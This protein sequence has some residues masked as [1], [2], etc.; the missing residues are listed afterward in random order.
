MGF[1]WELGTELRPNKNLVCWELGTELRTHAHVFPTE[2]ELGLELGVGAWLFQV[3]RELGKELGTLGWFSVLILHQ[4]AGQWEYGTMD[5]IMYNLKH[6]HEYYTC[7]L[8][9]EET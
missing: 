2:T 6:I 4:V 3:Y 8:Q 5:G 9:A 1:R 7:F